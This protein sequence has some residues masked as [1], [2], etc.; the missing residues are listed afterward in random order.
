VA[1]CRAVAL[2]CLTLSVLVACE[3]AM[4]GGQPVGDRCSGDGQ[5]R[6]G[7]YCHY[8]RCRQACTYDRDCEAGAVCVPSVDDPSVYVCTLSGEGGGAACPDGLGDDGTGVC[9]RPCPMDGLRS[10]SVCVTQSTP[11]H[12]QVFWA[13]EASRRSECRRAA[14][15]IITIA[16]PP[17]RRGP[18]IP[19]ETPNPA[20]RCVPFGWNCAEVQSAASRR[21]DSFLSTPV[22]MG[23]SRRETDS[24]SGLP[25]HGWILALHEVLLFLP[26]S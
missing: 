16:K 21:H 15:S 9:R 13:P 17:D 22:G 19:P 3:L 20:E 18:P 25:E 8:G 2:I 14:C 11:N 4:D 12:S 26:A 24:N 6:S 1:L 10:D 23:S 7:L 5:C